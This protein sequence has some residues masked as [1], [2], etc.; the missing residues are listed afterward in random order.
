MPEKHTEHRR[1]WCDNCREITLHQSS[2]WGKWKTWAC[3]K[4]KQVA[5]LVF[6]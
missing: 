3:A 2:G 6:V 4:C 5:R 1:M